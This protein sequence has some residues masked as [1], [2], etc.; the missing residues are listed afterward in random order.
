MILLDGKYVSQQRRE[1]LQNEM[2]TFFIQHSKHRRPKLVVIL[3]GDDASS[4]IY[5][6]NKAKAAKKVGIESEV[7]Q[8][9]K[10]VS[11]KALKQTIMDLNRDE[12]VDAILLQLPLPKQLHEADFIQL[13]D[14]KKDVDGFHYLNQGR[15]M[16]N[17]P[18]VVSCTPLGVVHLLE[19]YKIP[20]KGKTVTMIGT[21]NI[22][23]KPLGILL[24]NMG[25]T[26]TF[27]NVD[28]P[29]AVLK[30]NTLTSDIV[31]S[32]VGKKGLITR[33]MIKKDAVL[34]DIGINLDG[35]THKLYGDMDPAVA[36]KASYLTPVPG[37][38]GPMTITSLLENTWKLYLQNQ[39]K[40]KK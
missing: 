27:C 15:L 3:V 35:K 17:L 9:K 32:A 1:V 8:L 10:S 33:A 25:A 31:I 19:A 29:E 6:R 4:Q 21:S 16:E 22:V 18:T 2:E 37:G 24:L 30:T 12:T 28:T 26:V 7:V 13:I 14:P 40:I 38:V 23:G 36:R 34:V 39:V 20:I 5:V 11:A